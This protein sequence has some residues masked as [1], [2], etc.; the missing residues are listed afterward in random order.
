MKVDTFRTTL[1]KNKYRLES[2][3]EIFIEEHINVFNPHPI[4]LLLADSVA[5][6]Q[7]MKILDL[8]TGSG[9]IALAIAKKFNTR[10]ITATDISKEA[11][12]N[13]MRNSKINKVNDNIDFRIGNLFEPVDNLKF[14]LIVSN[15]PCMP[16]PKYG[17]YRSKEFRL[18]VDGGEIGDIYYKNIIKSA[19]TYLKKWEINFTNSQMD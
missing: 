13:A 4:S 17:H 3:T 6:N 2:G 10:N 14:D 11:I 1:E 18:A 16:F 7:N 19:K 15:P 12:R 9:I 5:V 8:C